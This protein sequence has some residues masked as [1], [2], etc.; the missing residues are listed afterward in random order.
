MQG[1][2]DFS[3]KES[4]FVA[5]RIAS[6]IACVD[7][8]GCG[9]T[10]ERSAIRKQTETLRWQSHCTS[11]VQRT[12]AASLSSAICRRP[13]TC[14][15][16][17]T[18]CSWDFRPYILVTACRLR[19]SDF[20]MTLTASCIVLIRQQE[21]LSAK[22]LLFSVQAA[23]NH[24][25]LLCHLLDFPHNLLFLIL[26]THTLSIKLSYGFVQH[27]FVLPEELCVQIDAIR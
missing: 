17:E 7:L 4:T 1:K 10:I 12:L 9:H 21:V 25:P 8:R 6:A 5:P 3:T 24:L 20:A 23:T 16:S 19:T 26:Q 11:P 13:L 14:I 27:A 15:R 2:L 18:A 22:R